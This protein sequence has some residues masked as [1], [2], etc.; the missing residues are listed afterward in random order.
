MF[1]GC[2]LSVLE[3][4]HTLVSISQQKYSVIVTQLLICLKSQTFHQVVLFLLLKFSSQMC[5]V[6]RTN[7]QIW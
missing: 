3:A 6:F 7:C 2:V 5:K 4:L 1:S